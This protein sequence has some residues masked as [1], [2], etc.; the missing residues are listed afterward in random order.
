[1]VSFKQRKLNRP[2]WG[3]AHKFNQKIEKSNV[4]MNQKSMITKAA[5]RKKTGPGKFGLSAEIKSGLGLM[6]KLWEC[7]NVLLGRNSFSRTVL[8]RFVC[9]A[10]HSIVWRETS[11][12]IS[13]FFGTSLQNGQSAL[14]I[15]SME[16]VKVAECNMEALNW[17]VCDRQLNLLLLN[18]IMHDFSL[19]NLNLPKVQQIFH[20]Q[21]SLCT[22]VKFPKLTKVY[23]TAIF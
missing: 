23:T 4:E 16:L 1:M 3:D 14:P 13:R 8:L 10:G 9:R 6:C 18:L 21:A 5:C 19:C 2:A 11:I 12:K 7:A 20:F 15:R 17:L 22:R